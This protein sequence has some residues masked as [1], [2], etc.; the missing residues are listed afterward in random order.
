ML[1]IPA[2][3]AVTDGAILLGLTGEKAAAERHGTGFMPHHAT[4][5]PAWRRACER[6]GLIYLDPTAEVAPTLERLAGCEAIVT[7]AMHGAIVADTLRV[8]WAAVATHPKINRFKWQDWCA[9]MGV[10]YRPARVPALWPD[11]RGRVARAK[12]AL[13]ERLAAVALARLARRPPVQLSTDARFTAALAETA[14]RLDG[15]RAEL[16]TRSEG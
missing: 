9:S 8:P 3:D 16:R 5:G 13:K 12:Q 7:E 2:R 1:K 14:A 4:A 6:A 11:P 15:L 10:A